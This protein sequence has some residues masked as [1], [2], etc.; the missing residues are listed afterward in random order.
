VLLGFSEVGR[1]KSWRQDTWPGR[2]VAARPAGPA[3]QPRP[4]TSTGPAASRRG[5]GRGAPSGPE[6]WVYAAGAS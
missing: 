5:T 1:H 6:V 3:S 2:V 4:R